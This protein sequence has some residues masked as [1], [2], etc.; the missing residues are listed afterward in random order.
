[1]CHV[2][3]K[4]WRCGSTVHEL[5][6]W[7][8]GCLRPY[9]S[10]VSISDTKEEHCIEMKYAICAFWIT[11]CF[12]QVNLASLDQ[13]N[14]QLSACG[15][16]LHKDPEE[17]FIFRVSYTGCFVQQQ[18]CHSLQDYSIHFHKPLQLG[19]MLIIL[20][21]YDDCS[22]WLPCPDSELGEE[23]KPIRR[24][25]SQFHD[26]VSRGSCAAQ[27]RANP[28]WPGVYPGNCWLYCS[29]TFFCLN[30]ALYCHSDMIFIRL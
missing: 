27:Q 2:F 23:D 17:N 13:L 30:R 20:W 5:K 9:R 8:S 29:Q 22:A 6:G 7:E 18:V 16:S 3:L 19:V 21:L 26:E 1:M 25:T 15:F 28:V 12:P 11:F 24:Q 10:K 4:T 14:L